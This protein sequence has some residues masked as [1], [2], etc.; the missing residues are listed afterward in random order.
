MLASNLSSIQPEAVTHVTSL[1]LP[2]EDNYVAHNNNHE[3]TKGG[4]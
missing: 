1:G 2:I 4:R 3:F